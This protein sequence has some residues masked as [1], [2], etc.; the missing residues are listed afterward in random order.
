MAFFLFV[1]GRPPQPP[2]THTRPR[3]HARTHPQLLVQVGVHAG[4]DGERGNVDGH[5]DDGEGAD[6]E[7]GEELRGDHVPGDA[8]RVEAREDARE[9]PALVGDTDAGRGARAWLEH[10][11]APAPASA[12]AG[13]LLEG[14]EP[15]R[16]ARGGEGHVECLED[17]EEA[18]GDE[19]KVDGRQDGVRDA[20]LERAEPDGERGRQ[21]DLAE[22]RGVQLLGEDGG[23]PGPVEAAGDADA[24]G[25]N[26]DAHARN[27]AH[28][29]VLRAE[30]GDCA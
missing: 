11:V 15:P 10:G 2:P 23:L 5:V 24:L 28:E 4:G 9:A 3:T 22:A 18:G 13:G 14:E 17:E 29:H 21:R 30:G 6:G 7:E 27:H 19:H 16:G 8:P 20:R 1:V 12:G 26:E 25:E